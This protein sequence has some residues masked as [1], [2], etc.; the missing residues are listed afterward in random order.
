MEAPIRQRLETLRQAVLKLHKTLIDSERVTYE[1]TMGRIQSSGQFLQLV[2]TDPWFAWLQP[3]SQLI[4]FMDEAQ[5]A[6]VLPRA[7]EVEALKQQ[8]RRLLTPSEVGECFSRHY[9]DAM[10]RDPDVVL[11]HGALMKVLGAG[12]AKGVF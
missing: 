4:V 5:D 10:Q 11:A 7:A 9:H 2:T 12:K 6:K 8:T 1:Q 3:L